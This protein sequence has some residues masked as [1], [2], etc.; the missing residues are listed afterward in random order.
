MKKI[1]STT[2]NNNKDGVKSTSIKD[3]MVSTF[4]VGLGLSFI[5]SSLI[6]LGKI[7]LGYIATVSLATIVGV[8]GII[9]LVSN[10]RKNG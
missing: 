9:V 7:E 10:S 8:S 6:L 1:K 3:I 4:N 2:N 5:M